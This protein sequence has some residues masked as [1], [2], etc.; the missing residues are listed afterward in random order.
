MEIIMEMIQGAKQEVRRD[1]RV[2]KEEQKMKKLKENEGLIKE[3]R[4]LKAE[5]HRI[6]EKVEVIYKKKNRNNVALQR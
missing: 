3:N 6:N 2:I 5:M 4:E 1:L